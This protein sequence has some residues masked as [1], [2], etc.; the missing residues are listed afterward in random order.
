MT[1]GAKQTQTELT[2]IDALQ[3]SKWDR[4]T[5]LEL[6]AGGCMCVN[7]TCAFWE[8]ARTTLDN[9]AR[10]Y[11][12]IRDNSDLVALARSGADI[13]AAREQGKTAIVLGLQN[14]SPF[15]D[16]IAL[17]EV[18]HTLGIRVTQLTY[19]IQNLVG[20]SCY[21]PHDSGLSRFGQQVVRQMNRLGMVID[22]SHVGE[23]TSL[24]VL[25]ASTR[26]VAITHANPRWF[27]LHPRN[28]SDELLKALAE[29]GG[30]LGLCLYPHML[31]GAHVTLRQFCELAARTVEFMG[32]EHVG[33]GS[34][35]AQG[36][37]EDYLT[38]MRMGRWIQEMDYGA[39]S[40]AQ[41]G[42]PDWPTW[43]QSAADYPNI[44]RAL[45]E[46]GFSRDEVAAIMGG[47]WLRFFS[48]GF[49]PA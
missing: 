22:L 36:W 15:E 13:E 20:G 35:L 24:D 29:Q 7:I 37:P 9:I 8:D 14:T 39:G 31:G 5:L 4:Q 26:P 16:D 21:E 17:V 34:D 28:K 6:R 38:W 18:F 48:E 19:N 40:P 27:H 33:L 11:Q 44:G 42:W 3:C 45:L 23:T 46:F 25:Q 30:V 1:T 12:M 49:Q 32:I 43:F 10:W 47:N 2:V 41:P